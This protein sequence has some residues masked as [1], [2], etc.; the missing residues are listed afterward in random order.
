MR[1]GSIRTIEKFDK[2]KHDRGN[3]SSGVEAL[4]SFIKQRAAKEQKEHLSVTYVSVYSGDENLKP[5][6]GYYT[7]SNSSLKQADLRPEH[8]KHVPP[9]YDIPSIKL[10]R[11]AVAKSEQGMGV[12][13]SLLHNAFTKIIET[14][15]LSGIR[16]VEVMAKDDQAAEFYKKYGFVQLPDTKNV[17]FLPISTLMKAVQSKSD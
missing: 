4:D 11:L 5:I 8:T 3:F 13:S 12:G 1:R 9:T 14:A 17:L 16:G 7:L 10:G 15:S 6:A 2:T